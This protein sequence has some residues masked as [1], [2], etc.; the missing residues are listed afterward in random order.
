[1]EG[2]KI[3]GQEVTE[4][5]LV[6]DGYRKY[7]GKDIDIYYNKDICAHVGNCVRGNGAVFEV[8]R[9]PWI[10]ADNASADEDARVINTCP[11]GA[12]KFIRKDV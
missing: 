1:M 5:M 8:G 3:G 6:A 10:L 2:N 4:E 11:T 9:R 12:L 7:S